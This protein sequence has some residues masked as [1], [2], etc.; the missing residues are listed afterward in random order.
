MVRQFRRY[1]N[2]SDNNSNNNTTANAAE[3][4]TTTTAEI[5]TQETAE[6]K[7]D[8]KPNWAVGKDGYYL[9]YK[10]DLAE[11]TIPGNYPCENWNYV[12]DG[13]HFELH[14][15]FQADAFSASLFLDK[16][17]ELKISHKVDITRDYSASTN[18]T[19]YD[20]DVPNWENEYVT[21]WQCFKKY[22]NLNNLKE[23]LMN[24]SA[25]KFINLIHIAK[26]FEQSMLDTLIERIHVFYATW[27]FQPNRLMNCD[28]YS[29]FDYCDHKDLRKFISYSIFNEEHYHAKSNQF[30][31]E[32][33]KDNFQAEFRRNKKSICKRIVDHYYASQISISPRINKTG[34]SFDTELAESQ[35]LEIK[36]NALIFC[37]ILGENW[38]KLADVANADDIM[39]QAFMKVNDETIVHE[40]LHRPLIEE[41]SLAQIFALGLY[42]E[43]QFKDDIAIK[44]Y[45]QLTYFYDQ[46]KDAI[47]DE[48]IYGRIFILASMRLNE[49]LSNYLTQNDD[50]SS[51]EKHEIY[52]QI[53][54][55]NLI[56]NDNKDWAKYMLQSK[57]FPSRTQ[58]STQN[59]YHTNL[60]A[61]IHQAQKNADQSLDEATKEN[62]FNPS[63]QNVQLNI[64]TILECTDKMYH[65]KK[66]IEQQQEEIARLQ[67]KLKSYEE[68]EA[69]RLIIKMMRNQ[70]SSNQNNE[71]NQSK[72]L[73]DEADSKN[74]NNNDMAF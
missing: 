13:S 52:Q 43:S 47:N 19:N 16:I 34:K 64:A 10:S 37:F 41:G 33:D 28:L 18:L 56:I 40:V 15:H 73:Q 29:I 38:M 54:L 51:D 9:K 1:N 36:T 46:V 20:I 50:M 45:Q 62:G 12:K 57:E 60:Q 66:T 55:N 7:E 42:L 35:L 74:E 14:F 69:T 71:N 70:V 59:V 61:D 31:S 11:L 22:K 30:K 63:I 58:S 48:N 3:N 53:L 68:K 23:D 4:T 49:L 21:Q 27:L 24:C 67:A 8:V 25:I 72:Q 39:K 65:Q 5:T 2:I 32:K 17:Q 44:V 6:K 26:P